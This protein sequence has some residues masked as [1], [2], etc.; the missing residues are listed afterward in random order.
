M[1]TNL[2]RKTN[3]GI[4]RRERPLCWLLV[5]L[6]ILGWSG[7]ALAKSDSLALTHVTVIDGTGA[8]PL[9]D[10]TVLITGDRITSITTASAPPG[11]RVIDARGKYLIPGLCDMHVHLAGVAA[12]PK[13]SKATLLPLLVA[14]GITT[15]RDM[16]GDLVALQEW[17][18]EIAVGKLLGP[19]IFAPG[20]MLD[21][22]KAQPPDL[23]AVA[24]PNE[25]RGA[26]RD[27]KAKSADFIKVLSRLD[28]ETYFAIA[29]ESKKQ[30]MSLVGHIPNAL[31]AR[32]VAD[33][34]QK[35]IEHI[36]YSNLTFDC[37]A[38]EDELR[39]K[40]AEARAKRDSA[41]AGA[42]RDEANASFSLEKAAAL[43]KTMV[44]NKTWL[45]PTLVAVRAI[46]QQRE[47]AR[48]DPAELHYLPPALRA[49]WTPDEIDKEVSP[50]VAKWYLAQFQNDLKI[51][52]VLHEAG[53]QMLA[54]SDS[55]D[56]L[57]F[58]GPS[59]HAELKLLTE[60]GFTP[61]EA[62]EAATL[63]PAEFLNAAG[64]GGWGTIKPGKAA[65][66]VLLDADPLAAIENTRKIFAVVVAGKFLDRAALDQ[67][68]AQA[69]AA[70]D[71]FE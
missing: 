3:P 9:P 23:L 16:G 56:P 6:I 48:S 45:V 46:A 7:R 63:K 35:S 52:R 17:R 21:G 71:K 15:V 37:S 36:F 32:E 69:R 33:A 27:L 42:A 49:K 68:L 57:N 40:S 5:A 29:D 66:L 24:T 26:V 13:W 65:D 4:V 62:L 18:K 41:G 64:A 61:L 47:A 53:V 34:G 20:P 50:E 1:P 19:R 11:A 67:L 60:I 38:R 30:G 22:G 58:P 54:G 31:Y 51:T 10:R 14:N 28:R 55:L 44:R 70:A 43:G 12:D 2:H 8:E 25:G 59:L 39:K